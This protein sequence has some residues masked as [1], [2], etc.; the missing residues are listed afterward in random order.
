[1]LCTTGVPEATD[2]WR[3]QVK[4]DGVRGQL[5]SDPRGWTLRTRPGN[6]RTDCFPELEAVRA[7]L[8]HHRALLD[9]E[10]VVFDDR[11]RPD[12]AAVRHRLAGA[13]TTAGDRPATFVVWDLLHLD[14]RSVRHL[15]LIE[16]EAALR[17]VLP[18]RGPVWCLAEALEGPLPQVLEVLADHELEGLVAKRA[19]SRW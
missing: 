6:N 12:F 8:A 10:V 2:Y 18:A 11:G 17:E 3:L 9:G 5:R 15:P 1:M 19:D 4:Y 7:E 13:P 16:R 14:G